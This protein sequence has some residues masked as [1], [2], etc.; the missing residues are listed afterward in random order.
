MTPKAYFGINAVM[1]KA[2]LYAFLLVNVTFLFHTVNFMYGDHDWNSVRKAL[3]WYEKTF[4]GRP[5]HFLL[6]AL[7]FEG[8]ILPI[9][10]NLTAFAA[11]VFGSLL[12]ARYWKIPESV[13]N[14]TLFAVFLG[15]LPYTLVWL[16][17]AQDT[18]INL[19]LPLIGV[20]G[21]MLADIAVAEKKKIYHLWAVLVLYFAV[22]SYAAVLNMLGVML[23]GKI[24]MDYTYGQRPLL[25][26]IKEN[27]W[28]AVDVAVAVLLLVVTLAN[29]PVDMGYNTQTIPLSEVPNKLIETV[30]A[31]FLQFVAPLPFMEYKFRLLLLALTVLGAGCAFF[32]AGGERA[33]MTV[34]LLVMILLASKIAFFLADERGQILAE[35]ENFAFVP[36][37]DFYGLG[38]IYALGLAFILAYPDGKLK[39]LGFWL[40][41]LLAFMGIV[42]DVYA[43]KVWKLGFDAEMKLHERIVSRL[44]EMPDFYKGKKYRIYQVGTLSLRQNYYRKTKGENVSLDLLETAYTPQFMPIHVYN[45]YYPEDIFYGIAG[46]RDLSEQGREYLRTKAKPFPDRE[47]IFI[48]GD[49]I[50]LYLKGLKGE[51]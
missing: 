22:S 45:F 38:F 48:D 32:R 18:L 49:I 12:L 46:E 42:R 14:Y 24:L 6:Q 15:V 23:L 21:L 29:V 28:V 19:S 35:M 27:I 13:T 47:A 1:K 31:M 20:S 41:V 25:S 34:L 33:F 11:L 17:Y 26:L 10:N 36:R 5:L 37:L 43:Q 30:Q 8:Q 50:I 4:E 9:F 44:E 51:I 39:K 7:L 40:A 2:F 3:V 16:Y